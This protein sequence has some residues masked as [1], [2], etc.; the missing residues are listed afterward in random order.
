MVQVSVIKEE[1]VSTGAI[2]AIASEFIEW[3]ESSGWAI[4]P[5]EALKRQLGKEVIENTSWLDEVKRWIAEREDPEN[6]YWSIRAKI[7]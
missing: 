3:L 2:I 5:G 4:E 6:G 1:D 7:D